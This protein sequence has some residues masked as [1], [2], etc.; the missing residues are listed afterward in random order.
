MQTSVSVQPWTISERRE[1]SGANHIPPSVELLD[2]ADSPLSLHL[3]L[4]HQGKKTHKK[5][6]GEEGAR[7]PSSGKGGSISNFRQVAAQS[8]NPD[9]TRRRPLDTRNVITE[10]LAALTHKKSLIMA[11]EEAVRCEPSEQPASA[12]VITFVKYSAVFP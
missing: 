11:G 6:G 4:G 8:R 1:S 7:G 5:K 12:R 9:Q 10:R 2:I 3:F